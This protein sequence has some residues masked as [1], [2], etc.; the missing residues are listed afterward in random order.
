[1]NDNP[2]RPVPVKAMR[3]TKHPW[4]V[5]RNLFVHG[6]EAQLPQPRAAGLTRRTWPSTGDLAARF[7]ITPPRVSER[8]AE[9]GWYK[10]RDDFKAKWEAE[11]DSKLAVQLAGQEVKFRA[12]TLEGASRIVNQAVKALASNQSPETLLKLSTALKRAQEVGLVAMD[13]PANGPDSFQQAE[14]D[15]TLMR[16]AR[17]GRAQG[18][19]G[20]AGIQSTQ[21]TVR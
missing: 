2:L 15:W 8:A 17:A 1:M 7:S 20:P 5:L 6:E 10:A 13:R 3:R 9:H 21:S 19:P 14:D 12:L 16:L 11:V 4:D 18:H